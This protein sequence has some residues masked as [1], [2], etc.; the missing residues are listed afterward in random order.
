MKTTKIT[1]AGL[2]IL[3]D[4]NTKALSDEPLFAAIH[5]IGISPFLRILT[6][7]V[8]VPGICESYDL[9]SDGDDFKIATTDIKL[10]VHGV[11]TREQLHDIF[12]DA[13]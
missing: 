2:Y 8:R 13:K 9:V 4:T 3:S 1:E 6:P 7:S 11:L 10:Q 12:S 5:V